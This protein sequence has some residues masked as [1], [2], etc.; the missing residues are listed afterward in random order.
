MQKR[1]KWGIQKLFLHPKEKLHRISLTNWLLGSCKNETMERISINSLRLNK[2]YIISSSSWIRSPYLLY[3]GFALGTPVLVVCISP[4][5]DA[6]V[7]V[8]MRAAIEARLLG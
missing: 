8:H 5:S 6:V 7:A 2:L 3:D 1:G 4:S